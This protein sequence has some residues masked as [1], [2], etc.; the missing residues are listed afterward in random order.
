MT[1][2]KCFHYQKILALYDLKKNPTFFSGE[3]N[4]KAFPH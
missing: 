1:V 4:K 2:N 3:S